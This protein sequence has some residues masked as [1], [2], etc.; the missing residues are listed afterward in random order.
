MPTSAP[1]SEAHN[2]AL[3]PG[4]V[5]L[6]VPGLL[7]PRRVAAKAL[8]SSKSR[9]A[10]SIWLQL[11]F[12][13]AHTIKMPFAQRRDAVEFLLCRALRVLKFSHAC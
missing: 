2:G 8:H 3:F 13:I 10:F 6:L 5:L 4:S 12:V 9:A 1:P 11:L 7:V